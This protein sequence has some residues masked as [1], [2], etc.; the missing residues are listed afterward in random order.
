MNDYDTKPMR[1]WQSLLFT[2]VPAA[3]IYVAIW[4]VA[5]A[6]TSGLS[7]PFLVGY[8]ICFGATE[9]GFFAAALVAYRAEGNPPNWRAFTQR[10]RLGRPCRGDIVW[11]IATL[12]VMLITYLGLG[13]TAQ[14]LASIP[15][16]SPHPVFPPEL[17]PDAQANLVIGVFMGMHIKGA[18]WVLVAYVI[19]WL[20]NVFGEEMWYRGFMLPRQELA[21]GRLGWLVNGLSFTLLHIVWKWNLLALL[22]G[23]LFLAYAAQHRRSTWI[24]IVAHGALN[25]TPIVVIAAGVIG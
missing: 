10:Y 16:F 7:Q 20:F 17:R 4:V 18:W 14:W 22:P 11:A 15:A 6:I 5:P 3:L 21:H 13:F 24:G 25:F 1:I 8:L 19:A 2:A 9:V 23:S 12:A